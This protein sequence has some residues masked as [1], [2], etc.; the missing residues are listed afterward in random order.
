MQCICEQQILSFFDFIVHRA[1]SFAATAINWAGG[2]HHAK[3]FEASGFCYINDIVIGILELLKYDFVFMRSGTLSFT[4]YTA[5]MCSGCCKARE[6]AL[7]ILCAI[8]YHY[9]TTFRA[10][11]AVPD[12]RYA[13][14][15]IKAGLTGSPYSHYGQQIPPAGAIH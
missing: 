11:P 1:L 9:G 8:E 14:A 5:F 7:A 13:L 4:V 6:C 3:K 10:V 12:C 2:L 15:D